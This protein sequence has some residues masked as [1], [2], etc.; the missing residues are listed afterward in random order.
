M[1]KS[2]RYRVSVRW[3]A[4]HPSDVSSLGRFSRHSRQL[5]QE[6]RNRLFR[7][8]P[9]RHTHS[10]AVWNRESKSVFSLQRVR[11]GPYG[12]RRTWTC[13]FR[14]ERR[15]KTILRL[16]SPRRSIWS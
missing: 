13:R 5:Q 4:F 10:Q 7:E 15:R 11:V 14:G 2:L 12:G 1:K 16:R 6:G 9:A 3:T 8:Q